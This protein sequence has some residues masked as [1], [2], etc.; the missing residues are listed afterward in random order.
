MINYYY[1]YLIGVGINIPVFIFWYEKAFFIEYGHITTRFQKI[2][3][4]IFI[5]FSWF[6]TVLFFFDLFAT[7]KDYIN[8]NKK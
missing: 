5:L 3:I 2:L 8:R 4:A 1:F 6:F 7:I